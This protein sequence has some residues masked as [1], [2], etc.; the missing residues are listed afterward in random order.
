MLLALGRLDGFVQRGARI[1]KPSKK[2]QTVNDQ[3]VRNVLMTLY[4]IV[5][6][7]EK[8]YATAAAHM[9][10]P[11]KKTLLKSYAQQR[12][13]FKNEI[14]HQLRRYGYDGTPS[15]SIPAVIHRG[16]VAIFAAMSLEKEQQEQVTLKESAIGEQ[17]ALR[18]YR[19]ALE[20]ELPPPLREIVTRQM[21]TI[22]RVTQQI[23]M[24]RGLGG[25]RLI[26]GLFESENEAG[27]AVQALE[28]AGFSPK[29]I[30]KDALVSEDLYQGKGATVLE[31]VVSGAFGGAL[32]ASLN[33]ILVGYGAVQT[34]TDLP[35]WSSQFVITWLLVAIG[36]TGLGILI[37]AALAFF[38]GA[39][40]KENDEVD[41]EEINRHAS[42]LV[43]VEVED[44]RTGEARQ[45]LRGAQPESG[46]QAFKLSA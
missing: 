13:V 30:Q 15:S 17:V 35:A 32:W 42:T 9:P 21:E 7:G 23:N 14:L 19:K 37:G 10:D 26:V 40:I 33:G 38:I 12:A 28:K 6:A 24:M 20:K 29:S 44:A 39:G 31:T 5:E 41:F 18:A 8:G 3:Q 43:G 34:T 27:Q 4:R 36:F 45:I 16:R 46:Q 25:R 1:A 2:G 11:A 22:Q